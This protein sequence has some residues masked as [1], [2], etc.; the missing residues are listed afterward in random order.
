MLSAFNHQNNVNNIRIQRYSR[1][2]FKTLA[3]E[4]S[5]H[6]GVTPALLF[7][8][9]RERRKKI[10]ASTEKGMSFLFIY[11]ETES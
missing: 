9:V 2:F 8:C 6:W 7:L 11:S 10:Q 1:Y 5:T 3:D 4:L